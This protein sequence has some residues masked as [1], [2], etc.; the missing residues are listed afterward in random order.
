MHFEILMFITL[1]SLRW[2]ND[3]LWAQMNVDEQGGASSTRAF[4]IYEDS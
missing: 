1:S 3:D 4:E 2:L